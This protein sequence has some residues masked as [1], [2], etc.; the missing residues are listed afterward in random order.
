MREEVLILV[1]LVTFLGLGAALAGGE[2]QGLSNCTSFTRVEK[3][4][5]AKIGAC[6]M[7][8]DEK[9]FLGECTTTPSHPL[10]HEP[11]TSVCGAQPYP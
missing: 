10:T 5:E 7:V 9:G 4:T 8:K 11:Y 2:D 6:I 1:V 3:N